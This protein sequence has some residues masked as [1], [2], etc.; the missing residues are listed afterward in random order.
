MALY[1]TKL[2]QLFMPENLG[3]QVTEKRVTD[4]KKIILTPTC[5]ATYYRGTTS[6][7]KKFA[8]EEGIYQI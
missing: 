8:I 5:W 7:K 2:R 6:S 1:Q 4:Q 3:L